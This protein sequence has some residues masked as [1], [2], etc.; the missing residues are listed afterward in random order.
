M[1]YKPRIFTR[2]GKLSITAI[3][4]ICLILAYLLLFHPPDSDAIKTT[5]VELKE[6][7][8]TYDGNLVITRDSSGRWVLTTPA[9]T[10]KMKDGTIIISGNIEG[11][12]YLLGTAASPGII[13]ITDTG[14]TISGTLLQVGDADFGEVG[15]A[16]LVNISDASGAYSIILNGASGDATVKGGLNLGT[17]T[18]AGA[19]GLSLTQYIRSPNAIRVYPKGETDDFFSFD[20]SANMIYLEATVSPLHLRAHGTNALWLNSWTG[21]DVIL[22]QANTARSFKTHSANN[23]FLGGLNVGSATGAGP[24]VL[25]LSDGTG[26]MTISDTSISADQDWWV[27]RGSSLFKLYTNQ[28]KISGT[29]LNVGPTT[30]AV[31]EGDAYVEGGLSVGTTGAG[32]GDVK[33]SDDII[34]ADALEGKTLQLQSTTSFPPAASAAYDGMFWYQHDPSWAD[35]GVLSFCVRMGISEAYQWKNIVVGDDNP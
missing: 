21:G 30:R 1:I 26:V 28:Q 6:A 29:G 35:R 2:H 34:A 18:G 11:N 33:A 4:V 9:G 8:G 32:A 7:G 16:G 3:I 12:N 31:A 10:V 27:S 17:A 13:N 22:H 23:Y 24:G 20:S 19:G 25:K 5:N 15:T 14:I